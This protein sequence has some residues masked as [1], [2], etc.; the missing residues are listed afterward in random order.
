MSSR[1]SLLKS[2]WAM[3][4][5]PLERGAAWR[6]VKATWATKAEVEKAQASSSAA[7]REGDSMEDSSGERA[8]EV[9]EPG[10]CYVLRCDSLRRIGSTEFCDTNFRRH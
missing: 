8:V 2:P 1:P 3:M 10:P 5:E 4:A 9:E 6:G 7:D